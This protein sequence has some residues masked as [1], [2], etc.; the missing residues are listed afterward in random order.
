MKSAGLS[1]TARKT[2]RHLTKAGTFSAQQEG[3]FASKEK[4]KSLRLQAE[5]AQLDRQKRETEFLAAASDSS[6]K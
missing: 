1:S 5:K 4:Q 2:F 3:H 6:A